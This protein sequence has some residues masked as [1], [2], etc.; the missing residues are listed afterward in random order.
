MQITIHSKGVQQGPF[1]AKHVQ[2]L[3]ESGQ[4]SPSDLGWSPGMSEWKPLSSFAEFRGGTLHPAISSFPSG[5]KTEPLAIWSLVLGIVS[6]IGCAVGGLLFGIP[7]VICGHIGRSKIRNNPALRGAGMALA[8][9]ITGYAS[10]VLIPIAIL[11]ALVFPAFDGALK[12]AEATQMLNNM[13]L[14]HLA[15]YQAQLDG[16]TTGQPKLGFPA[17]AKLT[18]KAELKEMLISNG[19]IAEDDFD[20]LGFENMIVANVS[21]EDPPDTLFLK[22]PSPDGKSVVTFRKGGDG[23]IYRTGQSLSAPDPPRTPAFLD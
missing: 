23:A 11:A 7:A 15:V 19:Y 4:I 21:D 12:K 2:H 13:R 3:L 16:T 5:S 17:T 22:A 18:S 1:P 20:H 14:I 10:V 9:L 6:L 8:G